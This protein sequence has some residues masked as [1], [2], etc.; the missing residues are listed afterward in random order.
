MKI[1]VIQEPP[2]FLNLPAT[3]R[4]AVGL[5]EA[6]SEAGARLAVFPETWLP[7]YPVWMDDSPDACLWDHAPA[8]ALFRHLRD[9]APRSDGPEVDNLAQVAAR[10]GCHVVMGLH[11]KD[12]GTLYNSMLFLAPDGRRAVHRKLVPTYTERLLWGRGDGSGLVTIDTPFGALGGLVCWEHWMP[13]ARAAMH[14]LGETLHVAQWP[15]VREMHQVA[16]RHYAFEGR[17]F[18]A[19]SGCV[20]TREDVLDGFDSAGGPPAARSVL[21]QVGRASRTV[22]RGGSAVIAPDGSYLV[23]PSYDCRDTLFADLDAGRIEEARLTLD[24]DGHYARP[25]V[26]TLR[27]DTRRQRNVAFDPDG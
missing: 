27:V 22:L 9:H 23:E 3:I 7:G 20:M 1:A 2:C 26:F 6:V 16:S 5:I 17:C 11:E 4:R 12:G 13:L 18:V 25:D 21:E 8:R 24:S 19:A 10:T 15:W 14:A